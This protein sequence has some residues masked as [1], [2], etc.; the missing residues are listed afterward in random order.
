M[1]GWKMK[2]V[3]FYDLLKRQDYQCCLSGKILNPKTVRIV[4][5]S[6]EAKLSRDNVCL[7][8]EI[9]APL[10]RKWSIADVRMICIQ[11]AHF[12]ESKT[13]FSSKA[14][15]IESKS[16]WSLAL[17]RVANFNQN[18]GKHHKSPRTKSKTWGERATEEVRNVNRQ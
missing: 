12:T 18:K 11:I 17:D 1:K 2:A 9:L 4:Q 3:D 14:P 6:P 13:S 8:H 5:I 16:K 10:A 7:V 15:K